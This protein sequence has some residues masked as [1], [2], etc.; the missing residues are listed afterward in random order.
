MTPTPAER[1]AFV[2]MQ[3]RMVELLLRYDAPRFGATF[4]E[5]SARQLGQ[6]HLA[7][8]RD[9]AVLFYLR[10]ELF[11]SILPRIRRRLSFA[12][13]RETAVEP[14]PPRG[15]IDW[16][17]TAAAS[18]ARHPGQPPLEVHTRQ[19]RR[20]F[21]TPENLLAVATLLEY[22]AAAQRLLDEE[23]ARAGAWA[24]RHPLHAIVERCTRELAFPQFA[25]L[26]REAEA[27]LEHT[28]ALEAAVA[29]DLLPGRNSAYDDL[30]GWRRRL[31]GLD[32]L[33]RERAGA[34]EPMLGSE[35]RRDNYLYQLW[36]FYELAELLQAAGALREWQTERMVLTFEWGQGATR[37]TYRLQHDQAIPDAQVWPGGPGVRPDLYIERVGRR[38]LRDTAG[39]LVWREPGYLLDA[40]YYRER[41]G[42]PERPAGPLKRMLADLQLTGERHGAL[43]FAFHGANPAQ[44]GGE[45]RPDPRRAQYVQPDVRIDTWQL[46]PSAG[47]AGGLCAELR[48]VLDQVHA[49][50]GS[51]PELRC[52]GVFLDPHGRDAQGALAGAAGLPDRAGAPLP[53]DLDD[54]LVCP[55]PHVAPWRVDLVSR[56]RDCCANPALCHI[57]GQPGARKPERLDGTTTTAP[58]APPDRP[59]SSA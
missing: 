8:E 15:R 31:R 21:T 53:A 45:L 38:E 39:A 16:P 24:V 17:R 54:L 49:V 57:V 35:P 50:L 11:E 36:L 51:P 29:A 5:Q 55:K 9:L 33:D 7:R 14:L 58:A 2:W 18:L 42:G 23:A 1:E 52:R 26:L 12:A 40:K 34:E 6:P 56:A 43:L 47:A 41:E 44:G 22:R 13:P 10:D 4:G 32:L 48:A 37:Q 27:A 28:D 19:R 59:D 30:L 20:H 3:G 46:R 25:G